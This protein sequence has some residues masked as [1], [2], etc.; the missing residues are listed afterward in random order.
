MC[1]ST[2]GN[3]RSVTL[4]VDRSDWW[5]GREIGKCNSVHCFPVVSRHH[6]DCVPGAAVEESAIRALADAF[7]A[8]DA[9]IRIYFDAPKRW[10]I[11]VGHPEHAGFNW[12]VFDAGWRAGAT[13]AA[14]SGDR[15]YSRPL[16]TRRLAVAL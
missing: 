8:A 2:A 15:K 3:E 12:T 11:F 14:V 10:V 13:R 16:L 7:L 5:C 9:K 4:A 6:F 1:P